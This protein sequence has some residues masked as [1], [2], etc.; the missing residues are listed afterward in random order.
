MKGSDALQVDCSKWENAERWELVWWRRGL[1][2][3]A[4]GAG[5]SGWKR[6]THIV[7]ETSFVDTLLITCN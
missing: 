3:C 4:G 2:G 6:L 1:G 5:C 7:E